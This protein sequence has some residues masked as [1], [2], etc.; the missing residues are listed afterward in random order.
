MNMKKLTLL[1]FIF[2]FLFFKLPA[3]QAPQQIPSY[4]LSIKKV[5]VLN[6]NIDNVKNKFFL[7]IFPP[8]EENY[9]FFFLLQN[10][11]GFNIR[12]NKS[13]KISVAEKPERPR[14]NKGINIPSIELIF[15]K[16]SEPHQTIELNPPL[17]QP[18]DDV[19][20]IGKKHY[21]DLLN[22]EKDL[23]TIE[24]IF[25]TKKK[26]KYYKESKVI[27]NLTDSEIKHI[28]SLSNSIVQTCKRFLPNIQITVKAE[29]PPNKSQ[30]SQKKAW[31]KVAPLSQKVLGVLAALGLAGLATYVYHYYYGK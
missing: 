4:T 19:R 24:Y 15:V 22:K 28:L 1:Y 29:S 30:S 9:S 10:L 17:M 16:D 25:R 12:A 8:T 5:L 27:E 21:F 2:L 14:A 26:I 31:Y 20:E 3:A 11:N 23:D 6:T 13:Y 18:N 7:L